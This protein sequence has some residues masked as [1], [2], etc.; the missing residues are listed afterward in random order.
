M[1]DLASHQ[2]HEPCPLPDDVVRRQ[3]LARRQ[4][5]PLDYLDQLLMRLRQAS[6]IVSTRGR[7]GGYRLARQACEITLWDF[8]SAVEDVSFPVECLGHDTCGLEGHCASQQAWEMIFQS[9]YGPMRSLTFED[10]LKRVDLFPSH[11]IT[12]LPTHQMAQPSCRSGKH[13]RTL[14]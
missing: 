10:I 2:N 12:S 13:V 9:I 4:G 7:R 6:L 8:F 11:S 1:L 14:D 3:D 5:I